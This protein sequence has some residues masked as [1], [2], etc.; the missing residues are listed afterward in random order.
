MCIRIYFVD[1]EIVPH[2]KVPV[3]VGY[4]KDIDRNKESKT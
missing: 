4:D 2:C 3:K 1:K